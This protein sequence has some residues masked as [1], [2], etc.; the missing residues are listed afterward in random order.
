MS[1]LRSAERGCGAGWMTLLRGVVVLVEWKSWNGKLVGCS[2]GHGLAS[3]VV[4]DFFFVPDD[5][6]VLLVVVLRAITILLTFR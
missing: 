1:T 5:F 2:Y 4:V 3:W 6:L